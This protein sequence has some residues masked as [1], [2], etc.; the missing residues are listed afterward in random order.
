[1]FNLSIQNP[2]ALMVLLWQ[3]VGDVG[4][5]NSGI[6]FLLVNVERRPRKS[7]LLYSY[8]VLDQMHRKS[9]SSLSLQKMSPQMIMRSCLVNS[10]I[11]V[12]QEKIQ[13]M[14][15]IDSGPGTKIRVNQLTNGSRNCV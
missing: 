1:M 4:K 3:T 8:I 15:G 5:S 7:K 11:T 6:I 10:K 9:T 13:S 12:I 14:R 2:S